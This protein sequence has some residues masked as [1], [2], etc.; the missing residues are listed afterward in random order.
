MVLTLILLMFVL[1]FLG[2][3]IFVA[4][5]LSSITSLWFFTDLSPMIIMQR[6][7]GGIDKF[8]LMSLPFFILVANAMDVGGLSTRIIRWCRTLVGHFSGGLAMTTQTAASFFGALSGSSPATVIAVGKVLYPELLKNGYTKS[9]SSGLIIQSGSVS[10]LIPPSITLILYATSTNTSVGALFMAGLGAGLLYSIVVLGYTYFYSKKNNLQKEPKATKYEFW[11][12]TKEASWSILVPV[13]IMGGIFL[14]VFTPT[15]S[16]GIAALY[17]IF[18][19]MAVYKEITMKKLYDLCLSTAG[20]TAQIMILIGAASAFGWVLTIAKVPLEMSNYLAEQFVADWSFLLFLNLILLLIGMFLDSTIAL[21]IIAPL[22]L[23]AALSFGI[24]PVHLGII[25]VLNLAIGTFT[26]PF[27]LNIFVAN[28]ITK[29][30]LVEMIPGLVRFIV[31]ALV[32]LIVVTFV[33]SISM[34]LPDL[35]Y[36]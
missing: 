34:V 6:V 29:M 9:F 16:A 7:F 15:E 21:V 30:S 31:V 32:I 28:S 11:K 24:D 20:T 17:S 35:I 14:G 1:L 2:V 3:P 22:I 23:P 5:L 27:G 25:M 13:I 8:V 4:L 18:V 12:A 10:L 19:G 36:S 26:P 33:P